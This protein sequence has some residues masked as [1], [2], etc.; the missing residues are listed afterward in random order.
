MFVCLSVNLALIEMLTHIKSIFSF[1]RTRLAYTDHQ[2]QMNVYLGKIVIRKLYFSLKFY[3]FTFFC[4]NANIKQLYRQFSV[5]SFYITFKVMSY[6]DIEISC[7][8]WEQY[9]YQPSSS[10]GT[11]SPTVRQCMLIKE[12]YKVSEAYFAY[13]GRGGGP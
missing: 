11:C 3:F 1:R 2:V 5:S 7:E 8:V 12:L 4:E 10:Q 9:E 13:L 6:F